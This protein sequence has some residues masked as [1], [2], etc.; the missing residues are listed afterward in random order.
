MTGMMKNETTV[1]QQN[2]MHV[3]L[4]F[5]SVIIKPPSSSHF[6]WKYVEIFICKVFFLAF[7]NILFYK[8]I[9]YH[10]TIVFFE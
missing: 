6:F 8:T 3:I 7:E 5:S 10:K 2:P 1:F 4:Y 9:L